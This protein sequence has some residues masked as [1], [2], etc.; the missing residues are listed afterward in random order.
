VAAATHAERI[1]DGEVQFE[2]VQDEPGG[3]RSLAQV[4]LPGATRAPRAIA[5]D[6][7]VSAA[8]GEG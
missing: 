1:P 3:L 5:D 2:A 8:S 7:R 4:A 6:V